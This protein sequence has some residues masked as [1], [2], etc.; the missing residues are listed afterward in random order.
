MSTSRW[1]LRPARTA[2]EFSTEVRTVL[3]GAGIDEA[4][5]LS[6]V[7]EA[8]SDAFSPWTDAPALRAANAGSAACRSLASK[9]DPQPAFGPAN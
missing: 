2:I 7:E 4:M 9:P 6:A 8:A 5:T 3:V 1:L